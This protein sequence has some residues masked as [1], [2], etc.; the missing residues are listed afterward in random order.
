MRRATLVTRSVSPGRGVSLLARPPI[1]CALGRCA[2]DGLPAD[3]EIEDS[4]KGPA[5]SNAQGL[6]LGNLDLGVCFALVHGRISNPRFSGKRGPWGQFPRRPPLTRRGRQSRL[7]SAVIGSARRISSACPG[8]LLDASSRRARSPG[9]GIA[10]AR[11]LACHCRQSVP[12]A[13]Q[14]PACRRPQCSGVVAAW[15]PGQDEL[16]RQSPHCL[17]QA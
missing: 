9:S 15:P 1:S 16:T 17:S 7:A 6:K 3:E 11:L 14:C 12:V 8:R 13:H 2:D 4:L 5:T 10:Q